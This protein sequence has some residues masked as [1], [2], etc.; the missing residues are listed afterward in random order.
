[1]GIAAWK[2]HQVAALQG[3]RRAAAGHAQ[4]AVSPDDD[5]EIC[6]LSSNAWDAHAAK[7]FGF[8][9]VWCNRFGQAPERIPELPDEEI[10]TVSALPGILGA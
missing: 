10:S 1:V 6:F 9:V 8:H 2:G 3:N 4:P 5:V 7:A